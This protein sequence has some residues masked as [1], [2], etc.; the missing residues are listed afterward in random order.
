MLKYKVV[1]EPTVEPVTLAEIK[2]HLRL[3]SGTL[4]GDTV[5]SQCIVPGL[6]TAI[7]AYGLVGASVDV[8]G[9]QVLVNLSTG[10]CGSGGSVA[11]KVQESDDGTLWQD[12]PGG[13]FTTVTESNDNA[14]QELAYTGAKQYIRV[15]ATV[16]IASCSF[17]ADVV[18]I[19]GDPA[20]DAMLQDFVTAARAWCEQHLSRALA[21]QTLEAYPE[22]FPSAGYIGGYSMQG[23]KL[24]MAPLQSV[25]SIKYKDSAGTETTLAASAYIVDTDSDPGVVIPAYGTYWPSFTPYPVNPVKVRYVAGYTTAPK[26]IKNAIKMLAGIMY[27]SR[28]TL[29]PIESNAEYRAVVWL[30]APY[31]NR[32]WD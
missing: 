5:T 11:A 3:T 25:T 27:R 24:P 29:E 30:L 2:Q 28:D 21:T 13:A 16:A 32:W 23:I 9:K 17:A 15:V 19:T 26:P 8:L 14:V 20:E 22:T 31:R 1:T 18:A 7:A 4:A 6:H 10:A 12:F